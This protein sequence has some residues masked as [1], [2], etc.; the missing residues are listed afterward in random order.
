MRPMSPSLVIG[1]RGFRA[2]YPENTARAVAAAVAAG[3]DGV[4][5]DIR[6]TRDGVWVCHHNLEN[7]GICIM[8]QRW[9]TLR[10]RGVDAL[11]TVLAE[12]PPSRWLFLEI[13]PLAR[14]AL[15]SGARSLQDLLAG[16]S[17]HTRILSSSETVLRFVRK[18]LPSSPRSL[19]FRDVPDDLQCRDR[20][21]SPYHRR[22]EQL[23]ETGCE[24]H[25]WT[26]NRPHR[27]R[28]LAELGVASITSDNPALTLEVLG[29]RGEETRG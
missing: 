1:H 7:A 18:A 26:V 14:A 27:I 5:V 6:R 15:E 16:R 13:K 19:V 12:L 21:L 4:E 17:A 2:R 28:Q 29:R 23:L 22:V 10:K 25:P 3:A 11:E 9:S 24:L 8:D 20:S